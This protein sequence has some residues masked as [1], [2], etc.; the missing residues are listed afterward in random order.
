MSS[1][2]SVFAYG[3][4]QFP[5]VMKLVIGLD[6]PSFPAR[7]NGYQCLKIKNRT[8]PGI[9]KNPNQFIDGILYKEV[10]DHALKLLDQFEDVLYE[11]SLVDLEGETEQAF[12]YLI[13][14]QYKNRLT[15]EPW[16]LDEFK[17]K[18]LFKYLRDINSG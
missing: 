7:L 6:L 16:S 8:Y 4:L 3:T 10:G 17:L 13:K 9:V 11:R 15:D 1:S 5:E 18:Y 14:D 2:R 12:V